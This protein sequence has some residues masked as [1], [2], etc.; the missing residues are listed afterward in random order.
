M[1]TLPQTQGGMFPSIRIICTLSNQPASIMVLNQLKGFA[2]DD[3]VGETYVY[4]CHVFDNPEAIAKRIEEG[5]AQEAVLYLFDAASGVKRLRHLTGLR[6]A[7]REQFPKWASGA[8][9]A[10]A[11]SSH[12]QKAHSL[13]V[14]LQIRASFFRHF[15]TRLVTGQFPWGG[16]GKKEA[17]PVRFAIDAGMIGKVMNALNS[18]PDFAKAIAHTAMYHELPTDSRVSWVRI[19]PEPATCSLAEMTIVVRALDEFQAASQRVIA[20]QPGLLR[21]EL[22]AGVDLKDERL[23]HCY[24][25]PR[26]DCFSVWRPDLHITETGV[27]LSENDEMPGGVPDLF[28]LDRSY[29]INQDRWAQALSFLC[30]QGP[31]LFLVSSEWSACYVEE[32]RW[33]KDVMSAAGYPVH[34]VTT[35]ELHD[36]EVSDQGVTYK[37]TKIATVWRQFP[38]F[39]VEQHQKLIDLVLF[40]HAGGVRLIPEFAHFGSK[41]WFSIYCTMRGEFAEHL[42]PSVMDRLDT[43]LPQ[44]RL[45][46]G[47][48]P[49]PCDIGGVHVRDLQHLAELKPEDRDQLV[50]KVTGA[51]IKS[52]RSYGVLMGHGLTAETWGGW[53][54]ERTEAAQP[55]I[56]QSRFKV[57]VGKLP[58]FHSKEERSELFPCHM[59][60]R[61]WVFNGQPVSGSIC[62][63]PTSTLRV[64]GMVDMSVVPVVFGD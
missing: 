58:V 13:N 1:I 49:F 19:A 40:A 5:V 26:V 41:T 14:A 21:T 24:L 8:K 43:L 42:S 54:R 36:V 63:V 32:F 51:N 11:I 20:A 53:I 27:S 38:I 9:W 47:H 55:F 61:P 25:N 46:N 50:L 31:L 2:H 15:E 64:H 30:G 12:V 17:P 10:V 33:L 56:I 6:S 57:A 28:H 18:G 29:G 59:L 48:Q 16:I 52:A 35:N 45:V 7:D 39:E 62:A 4:E 22:M 3:K 44:S 60:F 23:I 34:M 37:G